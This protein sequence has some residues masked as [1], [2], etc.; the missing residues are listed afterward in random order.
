MTRSRR[1]GVRSHSR[2]TSPHP[3][4]RRRVRTP[5][6]GARAPCRCSHGPRQ[7]ARAST[8][9][10]YP[11]DRVLSTRRRPSRCDARQSAVPGLAPVG[12]RASSCRCSA[13]S[14]LTAPRPASTSARVND[15]EVDADPGPTRV[16]GTEE[17]SCAPEK[18]ITPPTGGTGRICGSRSIVLPPAG[19]DRGC[20]RR[21]E[22]GDSSA[23]ADPPVVGVALAAVGDAPGEVPRV[24]R[25]DVVR[26]HVVD[27]QPPVQ[28]HHR[29]RVPRVPV[30]VEGVARY[31]WS[32]SCPTSRCA[33]AGRRSTSARGPRR[34]RTRIARRC[35]FVSG[36]WMKA[37]LRAAKMSA[38]SLTSMSYC[39]VFGVN[40]RRT[41]PRS[42]PV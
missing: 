4:P 10:S 18:T 16:F 39:A 3:A 2:R 34:A 1:V 21:S 29:G 6:T 23:V 13:E 8:E 24:E 22:G 14:T 26:R 31:R 42:S 7:R 30:R 32:G 40:V 38:Y 28:L 12:R 37:G 19:L 11:E 17:C 33:V 27:R 15:A 20:R 41:P 9:P 35:P 25:H 36:W 5:A